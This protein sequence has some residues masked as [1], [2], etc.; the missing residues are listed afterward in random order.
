LQT[1]DK[2]NSI[3]FHL[4]LSIITFLVAFIVVVK[5]GRIARKGKSPILLLFVVVVVIKAN[6]DLARVG[7]ISINQ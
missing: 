1:R 4:V 3:L 2:I 5:K 7:R 6:N